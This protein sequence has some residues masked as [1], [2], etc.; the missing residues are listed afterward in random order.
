MS[1]LAISPI[2]P[3]KS[4]FS[5]NIFEAADKSRMQLDSALQRLREH[6]FPQ[7]PEDEADY[8]STLGCAW[9]ECEPQ[10]KTV[11]V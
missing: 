7:Q 11:F 10:S 9:L 6:F 4:D 1:F 5:N 2:G 8:N 3:I